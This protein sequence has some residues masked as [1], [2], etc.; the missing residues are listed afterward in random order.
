MKCSSAAEATI[1]MH[2]S[3]LAYNVVRRQNAG[4]STSLSCRLSG[5][6]DGGQE[7]L[8]PPLAR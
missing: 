5:I 3:S 6:T 4:K 7:W 1:E 2:F 8:P